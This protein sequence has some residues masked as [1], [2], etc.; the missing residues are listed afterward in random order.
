MNLKPV[1]LSFSVIDTKTVRVEHL[2]NFFGY[3]KMHK[4]KLLGIK[5]I[6]LLALNTKILDKF[7]NQ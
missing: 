3:P 5:K 7:W 1:L 4:I 2:K 6:V